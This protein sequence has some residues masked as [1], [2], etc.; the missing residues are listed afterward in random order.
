[1]RRALPPIVA[2]LLAGNA[3]AEPTV[4]GASVGAG[5]QGDA[6]YGAVEVR[7]DA[8]WS[9]VRIGLGARAV[10]DGGTLRRSDW[11]R[12][13]DAVTL[14]R[15]LEAHAGPIAIAAGGLAPSQ[16]AH[17]TDGYRA[18]LDD[19]LRTGVRA[20][21]ADD[22]GELQ[23]E[24]D[25]VLD[26]V[27]IGGEAAWQLGPAWRVHA[28]TAV[29]PTAPAHVESAI[30]LGLAR[31]WQ[32]HESRA[33]LGAALVAEPGLGASAVGS[34][35]AAVDRAGV[36]FTAS[37]DLRAGTGTDG[38]AFGPLYRIERLAHGGAAGLYD[39]ARSGA[40]SG[41][42]AGLAVGAAAP[43]GWVELGLRDRAGLGALGSASGG[44]PMGKWLQA[45]GWLAASRR[46][47][48]GAVELRVEWARRLYSALQLARMY[49]FDMA[50]APLWS[51]VAWF[52]ATTE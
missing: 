20:R 44:A 29:D 41:L 34:G 51:V 12:L 38:A 3:R 9:G 4:V 22:R 25:D 23:L 5:G 49:R 32:A 45:G 39:L 33:A 15:Y 37:A 11:D 13:A 21:L 14:L 8:E 31:T 43:A 7:L 19:R 16:L 35:S 28:A 30:E 17:V 36:R 50:P 2:L 52:G 6:T 26:P 27:V 48:A 24:I 18:T 40:T 42:G 46:D 10:W 47:A 1:M